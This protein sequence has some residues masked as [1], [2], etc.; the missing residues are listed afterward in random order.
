MKAQ[1]DLRSGLPPKAAPNPVPSWIF[2][3]FMGKIVEGGGMLSSAYGS[4]IHATD[5]AAGP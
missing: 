1:D 2:T 4:K 5:A 3:V